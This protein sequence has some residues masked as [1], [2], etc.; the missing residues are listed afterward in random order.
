M[1]NKTIDEIFVG[2]YKDMTKG[3]SG[4]NK[5]QAEKLWSVICSRQATEPPSPTKGE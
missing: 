1:S 4:L 2:V 3:D 5:K